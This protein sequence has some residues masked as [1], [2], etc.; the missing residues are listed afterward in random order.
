MS[1]RDGGGVIALFTVMK[2][3]ENGGIGRITLN[4]EF[5]LFGREPH[6]GFDVK[7]FSRHI[8]AVL[9]SHKIPT[10]G[11]LISWTL[12]HRLDVIITKSNFKSEAIFGF[13]S[14]N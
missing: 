6:Q 5:P 13:L 1:R 10:A 4:F 8:C 3:R 12:G 9:I 11:L 14:S 2:S 7:I